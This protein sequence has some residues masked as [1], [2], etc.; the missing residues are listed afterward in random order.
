M[1]ESS[2]SLFAQ[3]LLG[4]WQGVVMYLPNIILA[5][6]L[7][8]LGFLI[9]GLLGR[10]VSEV[11]RA[12]H[13]DAFL[14]KIGAMQTLRKVSASY[15]SAR[16]IGGLVK[17]FF[18]IVFF[19]WAVNVLGLAQVSFF[20]SQILAFIPAVIIAAIILV[21]GSVVAEWASKVVRGTGR[22][23]DVTASNFAASVVKWAIWIFAIMMALSQVGIAPALINT[24]FIGL[25]A[26]LALAGGLAF[27]LGGR[28]HASRLLDSVS[29][30]VSRD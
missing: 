8:I 6:I 5:F 10:A 15:N 24:I 9:G 18:I 16:V 21:V 4:V 30:M 20:L 2:T 12:A 28:D 22:A 1:I 7:V 13:V 11:V 29:K 26:M 17:W 14:E 19:V 25:I 27:G 3:S 23:A